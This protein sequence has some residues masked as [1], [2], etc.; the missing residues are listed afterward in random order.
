MD[1]IKAFIAMFLVTAATSVI[2]AP[3]DPVKVVYHMNEDVA[4]APQG[5]RAVWSNF[6]NATRTT[7]QIAETSSRTPAIDLPRGLPA[8]DGA[9]IQVAVSAMDAAQPAWTLPVHAY[10][11]LRN[12]AWRLVGF[13]RMPAE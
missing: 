7:R 1:P 5:Y 3:G 4:R 9:F 2:A 12:G 8:V 13:E 11:R 10:F 6:D